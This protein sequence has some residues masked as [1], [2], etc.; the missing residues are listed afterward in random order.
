LEAVPS[1][2]T[3][4]ALTTAYA[5]GLRAS[6]AVGLK[7][8][9]IDSGRMVIRVEQGKGGK[10]RYVMLSAQLLGI[11]RTYWRLARPESW[12]F[13]GRD[14]CKPIDVQVLHAACRSAR[15]AAGLA[16]RPRLATPLGAPTRL[17]MRHLMMRPTS[18][19][20]APIPPAASRAGAAPVARVGVS[21]P[22]Q[23]R[24]ADWGLALRAFAP[25]PPAIEP[26]Q[27][28]TRRGQVPALSATTGV[29]VQPARTLSP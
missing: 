21:R 27:P 17:P 26:P 7:V 10:D 29:S 15:A 23:G 14:D 6:E 16:K 20:S 4:V 9:D 2:K 24:N 3:R 25:A 5:A 1:L 12:L 28:T 13:P 19:S 8:N 18:D 22:N 11:L